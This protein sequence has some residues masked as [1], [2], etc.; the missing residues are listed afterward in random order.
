MT[1]LFVA[2]KIPDEIKK[3]IFE[4]RNE[5]LPGWGK[6]KWEKEDKIH[7]TLKFI[8]EVDESKAGQISQSLNFIENYFKF[9][10]RLSRFGF[11][12]KRGAAKILWIG[13]SADNVLYNL[14]DKINDTLEA[15]S[16]PKEERKF[17]SHLTLLRIN[18]QD[19]YRFPVKV[20]EEF[21]IPEIKFSTDEALLIKSEL[22]P[23]TSKYTV[24][25]KY[26][27]KDMEE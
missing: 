12:F 23:E 10:C 22:L 15:I 17:K 26:K 6:Y 19:S 18:S 11:F 1:R 2:L 9:D 5:I 8:G 21:T 7:L 13:L 16:I 27:L 3:K 14:V 4:L 24:I 25:K 20:F